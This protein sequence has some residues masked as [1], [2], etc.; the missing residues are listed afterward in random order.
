M[1]YVTERR[2]EELK[3]RHAQ[4]EAQIRVLRM[5]PE[6]TKHD[7]DA[8]GHIGVVPSNEQL[9]LEKLAHDLAISISQF[10]IVRPATCAKLVKIGTQVTI[11][12]DAEPR[13]GLPAVTQTVIIGGF[14]DEDAKATP[15][16]IVSYF[17]PLVLPF[18][19][20]GEDFEATVEY[21]G[22]KRKAAV[23]KI[24]LP[25]PLSLVSAA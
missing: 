12:I 21:R 20:H 13:A 2:A 15:H 23:G 19:G 4:L 14:G 3:A 6:R 5:N 10:Q 9:T 25:T 18:F 7:Q 11:E 22:L 17:A 16:P 8:S 1:L 24:Q